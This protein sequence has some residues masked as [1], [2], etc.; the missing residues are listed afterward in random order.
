[1]KTAPAQSS[2]TLVAQIVAAVA[3][4]GALLD[5]ELEQ[6]R[7][8]L[9]DPRDQ[10]F[11]QECAYGVL[12]HYFALRHRL[13]GLLER[14]LRK[15]DAVI[16]GLLLS[17]LYQLFELAMPAHAVV[18]ASAQ[19]C[20]AL[21]RAWATGLVNAVLRNALRQRDAYAP[22]GEGEAEAC[23]NHPRWLIDAVAAA[24]PGEWREVLHAA[25]A[26]PPLALRVN[27]AQTTREG[28]LALAARSE[29]A[30][31][32][33]PHCPEGVILAQ[34]LPVARIPG[35]AEGLVSVQDGA[36]QLAAGLLDAR[37][38][39]RVLDACAAPGGKTM[40]LLEL[41]GGELELTA[42]DNDAGRLERLHDNAR[43]LGL[44]CQVACG[45][46]AAP[47]GWWDGRPYDRI[48]LDAPCS[49]TGVIR[50]HPDI[51]LH[52]TPAELP[53]LAARQSAILDGLWPLLREG[54]K[55]LYATC[56]ILPREN[57][58]VIGAARTRH[59]DLRVLPIP[60]DWGRATTHGRQILTGE[61]DMDGFYY[62]L[63]EKAAHA[64]AA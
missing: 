22:P 48:L 5:R 47:S 28:Y 9:S 14:P 50:R 46:A 18:D 29:I 10:A 25:A 42:L 51:K 12:R 57:D 49:A 4:D 59:P 31:T 63:L 23:W 44:G 58:D 19:A 64:P 34:A 61:H 20:R 35:F 27:A 15:R 32:A 11:V 38:G 21:D 53:G 37:R 17:G 24:W 55:L 30:A 33:L 3:H 39:E 45:D 8:A 41:A 2:R 16:E 60:A 54:G 40:H 43:R 6:A 52:R 62:A 56:S 7:A 36:A 26:R 13:G 1:M